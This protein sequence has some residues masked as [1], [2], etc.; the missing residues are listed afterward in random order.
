MSS[1]HHHH[2]RHESGDGG[3]HHN[4]VPY[5]KRA[6]SDW[7]FWIGVML[8]FAAMII[9]VMSGDLAWRPGLQPQQPVPIEVGK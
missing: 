6:H 5:W 2:N 3:V 1:H 9:Y 4:H 7:R 8:M